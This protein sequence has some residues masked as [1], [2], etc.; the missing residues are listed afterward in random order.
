MESSF[1]QVLAKAFG[2]KV[3]DSMVVGMK[4]PKVCNT[5]DPYATMNVK[6]SAIVDAWP[7][8]NNYS[9]Y[10]DENGKIEETNNYLVVA[11]YGNAHSSFG[12]LPYEVW[13]SVGKTTG[14]SKYGDGIDED[15]VREKVTRGLWRF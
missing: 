11:N 1:P 6:V 2:V 3:G 8:F 7:G 14:T 4:E 10:N 5:K 15:E 12:D 9:Y 13:A